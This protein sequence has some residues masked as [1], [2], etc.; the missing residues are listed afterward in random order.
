MNHRLQLQG[1]FLWRHYKR[2]TDLVTLPG[3]AATLKI[4]HMILGLRL[5]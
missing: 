1:K 4:I 2:E 3:L 5:P